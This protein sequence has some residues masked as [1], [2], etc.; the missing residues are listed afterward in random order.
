MAEEKSAGS[1][2]LRSTH[3]SNL[4]P[5]FEQLGISLAVTTYQA[6]KL[7]FVR[8]DEG[9]LNTHFRVFSKPMGLA[10]GNGRLAVGTAQE[11]WEFRNVPAVATKLDPPGKHDACFLPRRIHVTGDIQIHEMAYWGDELWFANTAFSCLCTYDENHSFVPQWR[12]WFVE[13]LTPGDCCH[14]NGF[15]TV[16]GKPRWVTALGETRA[17]GGWRDNKKSG[18][19]LLDMEAREVRTRGLSMPHSPRWYD[20]RLWMLESG[21]GSFG[22]VDM[23]TCRYEPIIVLPGFTRG[24]DFAGNW[25]FIGLSQV[26][27]SAMFSGIE[28]T[29]R[30]SEQDRVCGVWV[31]DITTGQQAGFLRFEDAVQEVFAVSVLP[32][33]R[34][35]ELV[36][37]DAELTG[38][39]YVLPDEA[40]EDVPN[41]LRANPPA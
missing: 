5:L 9:V 15:A 17:I 33:L 26:R 2:P 12:P 6:G 10:L 39:S 18:G 4:P 34:F 25:A 22:Y 27:E 7:V 11:I 19:I 31:V 1:D 30:L 36:N 20:G 40:L 23:N 8:A 21:T 3:T 32:G 38:R 29:D 37:D 28:L 13:Q 41:A 35:P 14:L 24:L 16:D